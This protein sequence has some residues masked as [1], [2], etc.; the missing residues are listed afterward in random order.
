MTSERT[1]LPTIMDH[2]LL[3][4]TFEHRIHEHLK[5][6]EV[7]EARDLLLVRPAADQADIL[8]DLPAREMVGLFRSLPV[9][10]ATEAFIYADA[11]VQ[12]RLLDGIGDARLTELLA[13]LEPDDRTTMLAKLPASTVQELLCLLPEAEKDQAVK[14]LGYPVKSVGRLMSTHYIA[15]RTE[16]T[17]AEVLDDVRRHRHGAAT[18]DMLYVT[19]TT[20]KLVD[21]IRLGEFLLVDKTAQVSSLMDNCF[22]ALKVN[23]TQ[24]E[25]VKVFRRHA[26][27][28]L[29][30]VNDDILDVSAREQTE[31]IQ[32]LGGSE[33]LEEPYLA[34][35]LGRMVK[36]RA[37][38]LVVLF[39]GFSLQ[40]GEKLR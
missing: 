11:D 23:Q 15:V 32:K 12:R 22:I 9:P 30:V 17:V 6:S 39:L 33:A 28:A 29:P 24:E 27:V 37:G 16:Q 20:G 18:L 8:A 4:D 3:T 2:K 13:H 21:D 35:S 34:I 14:L 19:D 10:A 31:D 1:P 7:R 38:W 5:A 26:R 25:A 36:K 40:R